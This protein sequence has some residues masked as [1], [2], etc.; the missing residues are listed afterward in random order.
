MKIDKR[1]FYKF[2]IFVQIVPIKAIVGGYE[3]EPYRTTFIKCHY[4]KIYRLCYI[5]Y[6]EI[7]LK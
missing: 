3:A 4:T 7:M 5:V 6:V 2:Y 1:I